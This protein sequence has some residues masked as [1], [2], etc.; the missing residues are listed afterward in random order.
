MRKMMAEFKKSQPESE[1]CFAN[2]RG[3]MELMW[4]S[5]P[6]NSRGYVKR[7]ECWSVLLAHRELAL[8]L[9]ESDE[10]KGREMLSVMVVHSCPVED[11]HL[12]SDSAESWVE[13]SEFQRLYNAE[14]LAAVEKKVTRNRILSSVR[15]SSVGAASLAMSSESIQDF[16]PR[17][18]SKSGVGPRAVWAN[19]PPML[20]PKEGK[21]QNDQISFGGNQDSRARAHRAFSKSPAHSRRYKK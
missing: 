1:N 14:V 2:I 8:I 18:R 10:G 11:H 19:P 7:Q 16:F 17:R 12:D 13:H 21:P 4:E 3:I 20:N 15:A 9:G 5:L 6:K